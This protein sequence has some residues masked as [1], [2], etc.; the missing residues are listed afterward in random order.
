MLFVLS[1]VSSTEPGTLLVL[2]TYVHIFKQMSNG[3]MAVAPERKKS[4]S[5]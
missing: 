1:P 3:I 2:A 5:G 4:E